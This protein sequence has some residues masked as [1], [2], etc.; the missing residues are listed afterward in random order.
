MSSRSPHRM[1]H[2]CIP[3]SHICILTSHAHINLTHARINP[4]TTGEREREA[5]N[6]L[7]PG[8]GGAL[9]VVHSQIQHSGMLT[10]RMLT[11]CNGPQESESGKRAMP[12]D[13]AQEE[14]SKMS[15]MT[16]KA[17]TTSR[18]GTIVRACV[19][20]FFCT[21]APAVVCILVGPRRA[22]L[23]D[24]EGYYKVRCQA[25]VRVLPAWKEC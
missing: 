22:L 5:G 2:L 18:C 7:Q 15:T 20:V 16:M 6:S 13:Q 8:T 19:C 1:Q 10:S 3:T 4:C 25:C 14:L 21:Q 12:C 11:S 24:H 9:K 23:D 17:T